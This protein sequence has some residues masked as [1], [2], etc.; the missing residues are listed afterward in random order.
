M[1]TIEVKKTGS[2][3]SLFFLVLPLLLITPQEVQAQSAENLFEAGKK[4]FHDGLYVMAGRNFRRLVEQ[5]PDSTLAD[6]ADYLSAVSDFYLGEFRGC[7]ATLENY[8]RM[9]PRSPNNR[10]VSYW[11]GSAYFQ[12]QDYRQA[13]DCLEEQIDSYPGEQPY[14]DHSLLLKGMVEE[15]LSEFYSARESYSRLVASPSARSLWPQALYR[16]GAVELRLGNYASALTSFT[17][18]LVEFPASPYATEAVFFSGECSY[19]LGRYAEAERSYHAVLSGEP[20]LEKR[21]TALYRLAAIMA[22]QGRH[23]EALASCEELELRFPDGRYRSPLSRLKADL[24]FDLQR[25]DQAFSAYQRA[26]E[27]AEGPEDRQGISYNLG[28]SAYLAGKLE[29]C[30]EPLENA[31]QGEAGVAESSL[32]RLGVALADLGRS[33]QAIQRLEEFGR[34]FPAS[35]QREEAL[36]LLASLYRNSGRS[37]QAVQSYTL[38][39]NR[40]PYSAHRAEYLFGRASALLQDGDSA[41]ALKDFFLLVEKH[42]ES[43]YLPESEYSIGYIYCERGEYKRALPYFESVLEHNPSE[44]LAGRAIL[45]AGVG[46]FNAGDFEQA[47]RWFA[48]NTNSGSQ[49]PWAGESWLYQGRTHYKLEHLEAAAASFARAAVL[50][51]GTAQGEEALFW[52]GLCHFRLD[53]LPQAKAAFLKLAERYPDGHRTAE[54][55]YR[56]G[57]CASLSGTHAE[58]IEYFDRALRLSES[59]P[60]QYRESLSQEILYQKGCSYLQIADRDKAVVTFEVLAREYP[61]SALAP[62]AFFK[63]AEE[64]FQSG[65]YERARQGFLRVAEGYPESPAA[66]SALYWA[67]ASAARNGE[68]AAALDYLL[69]YLE[70]H[71][72]G[73]GSVTGGLTEVAIAEIRTVLAS[74]AGSAGKQGDVFEEFYRRAERSRS[75]PVELKNRVRFEYARYLFPDCREDAM[76]ILRA[77]RAAGVEEPLAGEVNFLV[78][79]YYRSRGELER[80]RDIFIG[81]TAANTDR[82]GAAAQLGVARILE[83]QGKKLEAAEEYLKVYFLYPDYVELAEEGLYN[84]GRV[85]WE[86]GKKDR[87]GQLFEKLRREYPQSRWLQKLPG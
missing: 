70:S 42:G 33:E 69:R 27:M 60:P 18:I 77:L 36:R 20:D 1:A 85:Y 30:L 86:Q 7:L 55:Y 44:E 63:L 21:E 50:L 11:L 64:D 23:A 73:Q 45:A 84:A 39:I 78:G 57:L 83:T 67:G 19:F 22:E 76:E 58:G 14:F 53:R 37:R 29:A 28:L 62:E 35:G 66:D 16:W 43:A 46:S 9:Y 3:A 15:N 26:L 68:A 8:T 54:S 17:R 4:A 34:R 31:L 74:L 75:L 32:L 61:H 25:Y 72:P 52:Q 48:R 79:E 59:Q 2:F 40:Y 41:E 47:L 56:A 24:L 87:A 51:D 6:E 10:R 13:L 82:A 81:I 71:P 5:F 49:R 12:L 65:E 80:A 38:L